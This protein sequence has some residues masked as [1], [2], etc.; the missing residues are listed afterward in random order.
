MMEQIGFWLWCLESDQWTMVL[1]LRFTFVILPY[2]FRALQNYQ[3]T[4]ILY[5]S[6]GFY[7]FKILKF[8]C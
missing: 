2:F 5:L 4:P 7:M 1:I 3:N 6:S 8:S